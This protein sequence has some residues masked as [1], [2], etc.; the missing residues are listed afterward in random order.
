MDQNLDLANLERQILEINANLERKLEQLKVVVP[1]AAP[2]APAPE[3]EVPAEE[4]DQTQ[5][6]F[7]GRDKLKMVDISPEKI[8]KFYKIRKLLLI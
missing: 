5:K 2:A 4:A 1:E 8:K 3:P 7:E 6:W